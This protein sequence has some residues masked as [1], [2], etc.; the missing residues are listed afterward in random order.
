MATG[1]T[2]KNNNGLF[3]NEVELNG[4]YATIARTLKEDLGLFSTFR[5][6][7]VLAAALGYLN[8]R[9]ETPD[10]SAKVNAASIFPADINKRKSDL[11]FL[12][13]IMMLA[14]DVPGYTIDDYMNK[15]FR[16][17]E[18]DNAED[19]EKDVNQ[20]LKEKMKIF[21]S[22]ACGGLEYLSEK[23]EGVN[24]DDDIVEIIYNLVHNFAIDINM[25]EDDRLVDFTPEFD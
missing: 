7:Y 24:R 19:T 14:D 11:R 21:N 8:Q 23:F 9:N 16:D 4:K 5:E 13:R 20:S 10:D 6:G 3:E 1:I 2:E 22:Y 17:D 12:Y 15:A 18:D 25:L